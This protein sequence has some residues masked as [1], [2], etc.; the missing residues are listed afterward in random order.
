MP[1]NNLALVPRFLG[2]ER[3]VRHVIRHH[4]GP[5][6]VLTLGMGD[7]LS[8]IPFLSACDFSVVPTASQLARQCFDPPQSS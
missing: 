7:S 1:T 2:K 8:D 6:P 5:E 4:L 3:A